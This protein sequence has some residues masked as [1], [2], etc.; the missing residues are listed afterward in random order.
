MEVYFATNNNP[1]NDNSLKNR[2]FQFFYHL[3]KKQWLGLISILIIGLGVVIVTKLSERAQPFFSRAFSQSGSYGYGDY[4]S[5]QYLGV[6]TVASP[7]PS[8]SVAL[9]P[10]P[11]ASPKPGDTDG[12]NDID[13]FDYNRVVTYFGSNDLANPEVKK[14]DLDN[15]NVIDVFDYNLVVSNFGE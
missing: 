10:Q 6:S 1:Q 15:N 4:G 13:I 8:S 2:F 9:S 5:G 14:A 3:N 11:T 7:E 12:D